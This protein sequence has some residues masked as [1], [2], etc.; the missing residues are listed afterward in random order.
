MWS[1]H[2]LSSIVEDVPA[3]VAEQP[4]KKGQCNFAWV[5]CAVS[6]WI[7]EV[8]RLNALV[9]NIFKIIFS[10]FLNINLS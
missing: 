7:F 2:I 8:V 6:E 3:I 9:R 1:L 5:E 4:G 10:Q